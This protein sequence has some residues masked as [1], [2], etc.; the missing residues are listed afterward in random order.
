MFLGT[1]PHGTDV[2]MKVFCS[3]AVQR[4]EQFMSDPRYTDPANDPRRTGPRDPLNTGPSHYDVK[5]DAG[6]GGMWAWIV[7]IVAVIVIAMLVYDYNR[8]IST[9]AS[10]PANPP[11]TTGAAPP[12]PPPPPAAPV[13]APKSP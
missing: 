7:G 6:R 2:A 5:D 11:T 13:P 9:A 4:K 3:K 12:P 1:D 8:P 10:P